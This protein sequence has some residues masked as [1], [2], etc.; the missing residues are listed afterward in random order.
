MRRISDQPLQR[1]ITT[2]TVEKGSALGDGDRRLFD[3]YLKDPNQIVK[4][5]S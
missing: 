1:K 3:L 2:E 4:S 5:L